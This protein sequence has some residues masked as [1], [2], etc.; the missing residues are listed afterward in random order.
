MSEFL[1]QIKEDLQLIKSSNPHLVHKEKDEWLF[2]YWILD[3]IYNVDA[4]LIESQ[5]IEYSDMGVDGYEF[6]EETKDLY[7]VQNKFY[8]ESTKLAYEYVA[9]D[10]L[11][12]PVNSLKNGTYKKSKEL[13]NIYNKYK[14]S[15]DFKIYFELYVSSPESCIKSIS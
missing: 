7:V 5:I 10:F 1:N 4:D 11:L 9:N 8:S 13:Q 2:N 15:D 14:D 6:F 3:N 12:R